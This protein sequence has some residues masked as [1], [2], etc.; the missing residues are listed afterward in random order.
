MTKGNQRIYLDYNATAPMR[1]QV[2]EAMQALLSLPL[3]ASS[4]HAE[5]RYARQQLEAARKTIAEAVGVFPAEVVFTS[6]GTESNNWAIA[7]HAGM[8]VLASAI[9]HSSVLKAA[10]GATIIPVDKNGV[11]NLDIL[12]GLLPSEPGFLVSVML[13]NNETGVIQPIAEVASLVHKRGG[14]LHCDAAQALGKI[15]LDFNELGCDFLTLCAHK[16]G[17]PVGAGCLVI[18]SNVPLKPLALGGGQELNRRAGTENVA[19][20]AGFAKA[21]ECIDLGQMKKLE[22]HLREFEQFA[23]KS[24]GVVLGEQAPRLPNTSC[25]AM[26]GVTS[27]T[28]IMRFDLDGI[29][30]SSGA[31]CTSGKVAA[32]HVLSAMGVDE[33]IASCTLRVSGGWNTAPDDISAMADIWLKMAQK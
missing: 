29:A 32:S 7:A 1:P 6:S 30:V 22:S 18:K 17:G 11:V 3:N 27:Q 13:A 20:I 33:R 4:I 10:L 31:A 24:G 21:V 26:Q 8:C 19:A 14:F 2:R 16:M 25:V 9:E 28:Q 23:K 5:G 15:P 12:A